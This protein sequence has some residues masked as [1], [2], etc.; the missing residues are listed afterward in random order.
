MNKNV[1]LVPKQ[2]KS[3]SIHFILWL[4]P[5]AEKKKNWLESLPWY[6]T[7]SAAP[8]HKYINFKQ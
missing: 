8:S 6:K 4:I 5:Q 1:S 2:R 7:I 3:S